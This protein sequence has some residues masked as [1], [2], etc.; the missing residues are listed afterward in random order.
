MFILGIKV[1]YHS[2]SF[3]RNFIQDTFKWST[4]NKIEFAGKNFYV[5][6]NKLYF[7][8]F[9]ITFLILILENLKQKA[10]QILKRIIVN[11]LIFSIVLIIISAIDANIKVIQCTAC[12]KG[13]R[14]L[15]WN[16]INYGLIIGISAILSI[17]PNL[18]RLIKHRK[19]PV[20]NKEMYS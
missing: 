14:T 11:F 7:I 12:D 3:F 20:H 15:H 17:L 5:F 16:D 19:K 9:G 13:T 18:I 6:S 10:T 4:S 2:E 1:A 8:T